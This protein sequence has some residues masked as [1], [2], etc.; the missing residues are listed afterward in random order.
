MEILAAIKKMDLLNDAL[1]ENPF[2]L[3]LNICEISPEDFKYPDKYKC[4]L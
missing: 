4:L 1:F 3:H 2:G